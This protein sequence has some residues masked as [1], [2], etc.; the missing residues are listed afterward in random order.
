MAVNFSAL[1]FHLVKGGRTKMQESMTV[2]NITVK[3]NLICDYGTDNVIFQSS[4][5][6]KKLNDEGRVNEWESDRMIEGG[7]RG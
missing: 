2:P 5:L 4:R 3:F 1:F 6:A 7:W